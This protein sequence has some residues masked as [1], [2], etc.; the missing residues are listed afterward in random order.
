VRGGGL[1]G[2]EGKMT[3]ERARLRDQTGRL[4]RGEGDKFNKQLATI[5][6]AFCW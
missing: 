1:L 3:K 2:E 4:S 5:A 6:T